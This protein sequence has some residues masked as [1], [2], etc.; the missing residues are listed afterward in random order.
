[1][2]GGELSDKDI[3]ELSEYAKTHSKEIAGPAGS[4]PPAPRPPSF[5]D[6]YLDVIQTVADYNAG[7]R[8]LL[9]RGFIDT[10]ECT[11][12]WVFEPDAAANP[13][14]I[15]TPATGQP[16]IYIIGTKVTIYIL[17]LR[18]DEEIATINEKIGATENLTP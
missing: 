1:R 11:S 10:A 16:V 6:E 18:S 17:P 2:S 8:A 9:L 7:G 4:T 3:A 14:V 12:L 13:F 5:L 15:E